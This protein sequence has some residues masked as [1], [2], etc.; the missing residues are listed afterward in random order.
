MTDAAMGLINKE[1]SEVAQKSSG[2]E[3]K[4]LKNGEP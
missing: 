4:P 1:L 2:R 3:G